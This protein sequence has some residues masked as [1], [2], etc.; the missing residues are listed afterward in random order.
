MKKSFIFMLLAVTLAFTVAPF[1]SLSTAHAGGGYA[2]YPLYRFFNT[3]NGAHFYTHSYEEYL[4]VKALPGYNYEGISGYVKY[5]DTTNAASGI[6]LVHRFYNL[7]TGTHFYTVNQAEATKINDTM[8]ATYRYEGA[9]YAV[10]TTPQSYTYTDQNGVTQT[11]MLTKPFH[12]FYNFKNGTH[13]Y[14]SN[15]AE[16][17]QVNDTMYNTYR[18]EGVAYQIGQ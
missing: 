17:S 5:A 4:A 3:K 14:T 10:Y 16:A 15:Q 12:R 13:F 6:V 1:T 9:Q 8:Y 11:S 2:G 18:Y 7:K